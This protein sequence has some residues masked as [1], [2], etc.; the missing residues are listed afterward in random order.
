[1]FKLFS[2]CWELGRVNVVHR[3]C[4]SV[5]IRCSIVCCG[6]LTSEAFW[7]LRFVAALMVVC[8]V[9]EPIAGLVVS[10]HGCRDDY[11]HVDL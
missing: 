5:E 10:A 3:S 2:R 4:W 8:L 7:V 1:M 6:S 9:C 11:E